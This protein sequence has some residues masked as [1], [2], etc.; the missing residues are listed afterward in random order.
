MSD[1]GLFERIII[2]L[3]QEI[4]RRDQKNSIFRRLTVEN[5][6]PRVDTR[7]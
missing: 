6:I 7:D 3:F 5:G 4:S 1:F 2:Q